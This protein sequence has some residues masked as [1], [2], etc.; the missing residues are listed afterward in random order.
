MT[1]RIGLGFLI[2]ISALVS[3]AIIEMV[4]YKMVR[5]IGLVQAFKD[6]GP[7]ADPLDPAFTEPMRWVNMSPCDIR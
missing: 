6:A 5:N 4:R 3:A 1:M 2:Q 7:K